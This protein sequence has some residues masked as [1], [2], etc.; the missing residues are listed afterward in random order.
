MKMNIDDLKK[1]QKKNHQNSSVRLD[2]YQ[3]EIIKKNNINLSQLTRILL[4]N[5]LKE[6]FPEDFAKREA[7]EECE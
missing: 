1:G 4:D 5:F 6:N 2:P 3:L 7:G